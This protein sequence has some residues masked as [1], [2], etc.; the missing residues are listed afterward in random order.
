M[1]DGHYFKYFPTLAYETFDGSNEYKIIQD[2]FVRIRTT[3]AAH[4]DGAVYYDYQVKD[5]ESPELISSKYYDSPQYHWVI[6]FMNKIRDAQWDW[7]LDQKTFE[8]YIN[9]KYGTLNSSTGKY[10]GGIP[11]AE[12][13]HSHY[14]TIEVRSPFADDNYSLDEIII[15][16]GIKVK[17]DYQFKYRLINKGA[18][19]SEELILLGDNIRKEVVAMTEEERLNDAKRNITVLKKG[20]LSEFV[21]EFENLIIPRV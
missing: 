15:P 9:M 18:I 3:L 4:M 13:S 20:Y 21:E 12:Q 14:E 11:I 16:A 7:P 19:T 6:L 17:E 1:A 2:I 5:G 8:D 10:E